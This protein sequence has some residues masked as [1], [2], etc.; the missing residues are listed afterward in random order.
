VRLPEQKLWDDLRDCMG[1][2]WFARRIEDRLGGGVP[3]LTFALKK[4]RAGWMELKVLEKLPPER[5]VFDIGHFTADQRAFG[6]QMREY[7]GLSSWFL[8]TR[9]G[10]VDHLHNPSVID[11]LGEDNYKTFRNR[12]L[13]AGRLAGGAVGAAEALVAVL[14][15]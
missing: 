1:S 3:D 15:R 13:W 6:L 5:R 7:G 4:R 11:M 9:C 14:R 10:D 8:L 2:R 12:A